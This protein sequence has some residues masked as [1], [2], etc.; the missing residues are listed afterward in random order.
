[1]HRAEPRRRL[2]LHAT[3]HKVLGGGGLGATAPEGLLEVGRRVAHVRI[4]VAFPREI[5]RKLAHEED[6]RGHTDGPHVACL[7]VRLANVV[8]PGEDLGGG[9]LGRAGQLGQTL[10]RL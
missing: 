3:E 2:D 9:V 1:M 10:R 8:E 4:Q 6:I 7:R 5:V